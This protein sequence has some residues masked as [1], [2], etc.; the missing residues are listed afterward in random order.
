MRS[1][2]APTPASPITLEHAFDYNA[3]LKPPVWIGAG[4]NGARVFREV[5]GGR[6]SGPLLNGELLTGGGDW[7][8]LGDDG[9]ARLDVRGQIRTDDGALVYVFYEGLIQLKEKVAKADASDGETAFEDQ[10]WRIAPRFETGDER[11]R[12][13]TQSTF[14][15]RG[16]IHPQGVAYE[17][18]RV[19]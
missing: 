1:D 12:W 8:L 6:V 16:R 19:Q 15:A 18:F 7:A 4:H 10:Y 11:Y 5:T 9:F 14:V 3:D 13:L 2:T 17:V